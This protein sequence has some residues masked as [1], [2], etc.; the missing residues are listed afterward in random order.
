MMKLMCSCLI[1]SLSLS[2]RAQLPVWQWIHRPLLPAWKRG[3]GWIPLCML[4]IFGMM[5]W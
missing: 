2:G 4:S 1:L 5:G 3:Q